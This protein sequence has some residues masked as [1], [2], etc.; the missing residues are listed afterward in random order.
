MNFVSRSEKKRN[1]DAL[2]IAHTPKQPISKQIVNAQDVFT[3]RVDEHP[4]LWIVADGASGLTQADHMHVTSDA[5]WFSHFLCHYLADHNDQTKTLSTLLS[6]ACLCAK[7]QFEDCPEL[8]QPSCAIAILRKNESHQCFDY[9][10]LGDCVLFIQIKDAQT[11]MPSYLKITDDRIA[12][13]DHLAIDEMMRLAK[14]KNESPVIQ[15]PF[16]Q[17][18]LIQNRSQKN[19]PNGYAIADLSNDWLHQEITGS[20]MMDQLQH[21]ALYSDGFDQLQSFLALDNQQFGEYLFSHH[22]QD[23]VDQLFQ[24]QEEDSHC[25]RLPRLKKRDDTSLIL[26]IE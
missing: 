2:I 23:L 13:F 5:A 22:A 20:I 16:V 17:S 19:K 26:T 25:S 7:S 8:E 10:L 1:E 12:D 9:L 3:I 18:I 6:E 14:Q 11:S 24:F 15:R 21:A 4:N